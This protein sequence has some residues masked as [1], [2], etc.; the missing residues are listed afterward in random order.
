[1][2]Y[3]NG[4]KSGAPQQNGNVALASPEIS[5]NLIPTTSGKTNSMQYCCIHNSGTMGATAKSL[6]DNLTASG[7]NFHM[8]VDSTQA[9]QRFDL[10]Y[11][12]AHAGKI[13]DK[14]SLDK[15]LLD[16]NG[17]CTGN[18]T[19]F[20]IEIAE[21]Y[22]GN[23]TFGKAERRTAA[24]VASLGYS[25]STI[26]AHRDFTGKNCPHRTKMDQFR[27]FVDLARAGKLAAEG[28]E[29]SQYASADDMVKNG[30]EQPQNAQGTDVVTV[31][32][33]GWAGCPMDK[34]IEYSKSKYSNDSATWKKIQELVGVSDPDGKLG[35]TKRLK[36]TITAIA[37]WQ[38]SK[39][40]LG[41]GQFGRNSKIAA[42]WLT[43]DGKEVPAGS[44]TQDQS[45]DQSKDQQPTQTPETFDPKP[46]ADNQPHVCKVTA[47][48]LRVR[49]SPGVRDDNYS[50][51]MLTNGTEVVC[52]GYYNVDGTDW[53]YF[54]SD[55]ISGWMTSQYLEKVTDSVTEDKTGNTGNAQQTEAPAST[56]HQDPVQ[57]Q[58]VSNQTKPASTQN[59][60]AVN[61]IK[62]AWNRI[63]TY[64][65]HIIASLTKPTQNTTTSPT[66]TVPAG[67]TT[68]PVNTTPEQT[69]PEQTAPE[70]TT[71]Q[72]NTTPEQTTPEQTTPEQ[73]T[74]DPVAPAI[75]AEDVSTIPEA[76]RLSDEKM[77][78]AHT[79]YEKQQYSSELITKIQ[80][81]VGANE[82]GSI[83]DATIHKIGIWQA[84]N[85][86]TKD[87]Q[88]GP[89]SLRKVGL[90]KNLDFLAIMQDAY[91]DEIFEKEGAD[92]HL[93][94]DFNDV[95]NCAVANFGSG[96]NFKAR[97][98][99][100]DAL[101]DDDGKVRLHVD[102]ADS[103]KILVYDSAE[104]ADLAIKN[105]FGY[106][107]HNAWANKLTSLGWATGHSNGQSMKDL[108]TNMGLNDSKTLSDN[109]GHSYTISF[110][111]NYLNL[112][113]D[114][115][116]SKRVADANTG[117]DVQYNETVQNIVAE[118]LKDTGSN[119]VT[120]S[121]VHWGHG[122]PAILDPMGKLF[123]NH[124]DLF[125]RQLTQGYWDKEMIDL[126]QG[127][128]ASNGCRDVVFHYMYIKDD[129][130]TSG[131]PVYF[132]D[133]PDAHPEKS[134][135]EKRIACRNAVKNNHKSVQDSD[136][137]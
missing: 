30:E 85:N 107:S 131:T 11:K 76:L 44:S 86:L 135:Y 69:T 106:S 51:T 50:G 89:N 2:D 23:K 59:N 16:S 94:Y 118:T 29:T 78:K 45:K 133:Y 26:K 79:F 113:V 40:L 95:P 110:N 49:T 36:S 47:S 67:T 103:D 91:N 53:Y 117:I 112:Y 10:S 17:N 46:F 70:Q 28:P 130:G 137:V 73:T 25:G 24:V 90:V 68:N 81:I 108:K 111:S 127:E 63:S 8:S 15:D 32:M 1:M 54:T 105:V 18:T 83:N 87:G 129:L 92:G 60:K 34:A 37:R 98:S 125:K 101:K 6:T 19:S 3:S 126:I 97:P 5:K 123:I 100:A 136:Y 27:V 35:D 62:N 128:F 22:A 65:K 124:Q 134:W 55:S 99:L 7:V 122:K 42:G 14:N 38:R 64:W 116:T 9:I 120:Q 132:S 41:D 57:N 121:M 71:E 93:Y 77:E 114:K 52:T 109:S 13:Y 4:E 33:D 61:W 88:F 84:D 56:T 102:S 31:S 21:D 115:D 104:Q 12:C 72:T 75:V 58:P 119:L 39:D 74:P 96:S 80:H 48:E 66:T 43:E 82:T 20:G